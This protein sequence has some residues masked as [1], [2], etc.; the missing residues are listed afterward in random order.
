MET[1]IKMEINPEEIINAV[2]RMTKKKRESF[3]EDLL[4]STSPE[5]LLSIQEARN[6]Y[7]SGKLYDH[8]E[9]FGTNV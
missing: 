9:V 5:Y 8:Q 4:A 2:K 6:D 3:I 7:K 1:M